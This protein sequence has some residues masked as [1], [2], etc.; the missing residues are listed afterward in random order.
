MEIQTQQNN[1]T[2]KI[3]NNNISDSE[4]E[5]D[6][7][8]SKNKDNKDILNSIYGNEIFSIIDKVS[9]FKDDSKNYMI[10]TDEELSLKYDIFK[11][12]IL[13]YINSTTNQI[14][15]AFHIDLSN[16]NENNI[17]IVKG[18]VNEKMKLLN[19]V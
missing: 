4:N 7:F 15:N 1:L 16:I 12:E 10:K 11:D 9:N 2:Q 8:D 18:F 6:F 3:K 17:K 5:K 19:R 14:I 13:K